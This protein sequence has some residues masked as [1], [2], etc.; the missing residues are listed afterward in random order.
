MQ[1]GSEPSQAHNLERESSTLSPATN[2]GTVWRPA[3][4]HARMKRVRFPLPRPRAQRLF[5]RSRKK[6]GGLPHA[7]RIAGP[8]LLSSGARVRLP[9]G[10]PRRVCGR[11]DRAYRSCLVGQMGMSRRLRKQRSTDL[12]RHTS[13]PCPCLAG[14]GREPSKFVVQVQLLAGVLMGSSY[15][16]STP[17]RQGGNR[18]SILLGSTRACRSMGGCGICNPEMRVR[19]P[20][21]PPGEVAQWESAAVATRRSGVQSSSSP[22]AAMVQRKGTCSTRRRRRFNSFWWYH[23]PRS[24]SG[25]EGGL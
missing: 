10:V 21:G 5:L 6:Y 4:A 23:T 25:Q 7:R 17:P 8:R 16:G 14:S 24:F 19:F 18:S 12:E 15:N 3:L 22:P 20:S 11:R 9:G 13:P 1:G 2:V